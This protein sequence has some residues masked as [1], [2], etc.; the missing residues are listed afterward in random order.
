[1]VRRGE[2]GLAVVHSVEHPPRVDPAGGPGRA[3]RPVAGR[4]A[5]AAGRP[6]VAVVCDLLEEKWPSMDLVAEMLLLHLGDPSSA[7]EAVRVRPRMV[8]RFGR[9]RPALMARAG[10]NV[11]RVINRFWY[12]PRH[13]KG[14][15]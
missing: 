7:V 1:M 8:R 15:G 13:L 10:H 14:A 5:S 9:L 2:E 4:V 6:R 11:D 12:Y 3:P